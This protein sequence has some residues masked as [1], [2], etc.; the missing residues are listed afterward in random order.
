MYCKDC[1]DAQTSALRQVESLLSRLE[2][3]ENL[4]PSNKAMGMHFSTYKSTEFI[5]RVKCMCL[6]Y[7]MTRHHRLKLIIL[8]RLLAKLQGKEYK[9]PLV[10]SDSSSGA[11]SIQDPE[12][13]N[14]YAKGSATSDGISILISFYLSKIL[15]LKF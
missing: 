11:S 5:N 3:A 14:D 13:E 7:N 10:D 6:W 4:F 2:A 15:Q 12:H 1:L 8:G 9:W